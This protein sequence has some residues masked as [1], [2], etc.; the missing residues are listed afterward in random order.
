MSRDLLCQKDKFIEKSVQQAKA[1]KDGL[2]DYEL[3]FCRHRLPS[4]IPLAEMLMAELLSCVFEAAGD[5][6]YE[7]IEK[8]LPKPGFL[9]GL[10]P[11]NIKEI[12]HVV[13]NN[14]SADADSI[15]SLTE[16]L[17]VIHKSPAPLQ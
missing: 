16:K 10:T 6:N 14:G 11:E 12:E 7:I 9:K 2:S 5:E 4:E 17:S 15:V 3:F 1:L 13:L 8:A